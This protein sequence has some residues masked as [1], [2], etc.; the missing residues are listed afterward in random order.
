MS[1]RVHSNVGH[2]LNRRLPR[3]FTGNK[4]L[5]TTDPNAL[6]GGPK[7]SDAMALMRHSGV[8]SFAHDAG[9]ASDI[10][11]WYW[12]QTVFEATGGVKGWIH[13]GAVAAEYQKTGV[14]PYSAASVTAPEGALLFF[15]GSVAADNFYMGGTQRYD[16][17]ANA[18]L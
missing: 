16:G 6:A 11:V 13:L 18:D 2:G 15:Q 4:A 8:A 3:V 12:S 17:N 14:D 5:Y 9:A 1:T 7:K 10:T